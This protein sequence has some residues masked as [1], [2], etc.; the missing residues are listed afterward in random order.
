[1]RCSV[2]G[3]GRVVITNEGHSLEDPISGKP[4]AAAAACE[5]LIRGESMRTDFE[6]VSGKGTTGG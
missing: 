2:L 5:G 4:G 6:L 1:M 3:T